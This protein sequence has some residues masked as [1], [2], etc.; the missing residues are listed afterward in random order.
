MLRVEPISL[1]AANA[2]VEQN[3][4]HH[5]ASRGHKFSV[6]VVDEH[7]E[8]RAIKREARAR[9]AEIRGGESK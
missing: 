1:R 8:R 3:H 7:A 6:S 9:A 2:Y 4:R 5:K